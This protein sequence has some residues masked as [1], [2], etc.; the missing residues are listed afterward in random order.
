MLS[1]LYSDL[2]RRLS[3]MKHQYET[4]SEI[5]ASRFKHEKQELSKDELSSD[6]GNARNKEDH[7]RLQLEDLHHDKA[8]KNIF[9]CSNEKCGQAFWLCFR[10]TYYVCFTRIVHSFKQVDF[11]IE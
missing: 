10:F 7:E 2:E 8:V 9:Q 3:A 5:P 11:S 6:D 1:F 4:H